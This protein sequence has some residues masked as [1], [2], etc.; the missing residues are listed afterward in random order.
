MADAALIRCAED[1]VTHPETAVR[2][3]VLVGPVDLLKPAGFHTGAEVPRPKI[4]DFKQRLVPPRHAI[5]V[6]ETIRN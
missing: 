6:V 4:V 2:R 3:Q 5:R 1:D